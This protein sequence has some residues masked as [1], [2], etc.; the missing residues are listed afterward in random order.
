[1]TRPGQGPPCGA[2]AEFAVHVGGGQV[3]MNEVVELIVHGE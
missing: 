1:M 2:R 3:A